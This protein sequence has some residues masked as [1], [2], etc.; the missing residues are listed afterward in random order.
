MRLEGPV[1]AALGRSHALP[2]VLRVRIMGLPKTSY[3][4]GSYEIV[5]IFQEAPRISYPRRESSRIMIT[6]SPQSLG[7]T[8]GKINA[9]LS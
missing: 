1:S 3:S 7:I 4:H 2:T 6:V 5:G 9:I 8:A